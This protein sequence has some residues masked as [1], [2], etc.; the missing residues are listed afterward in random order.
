MKT[1]VLY[2]IYYALFGFFALMP[3]WLLFIISD[4]F[5]V[6][7]YKCL[8]YRV[9]MVRK[10]LRNSFPEKTDE[11]LR[12]IEKKVYHHFCDLIVETV[13][14]LN[15][16][17]AQAEERIIVVNPEIVVDVEKQNRPVILYLGHY[18]NWEYVTKIVRHFLP[19]KPGGHVYKPQH[20]AAMDKFLYKL[21]SRFGSIG[22]EQS[23]TF[24]RLLAWRRDHGTFVMGFIA[25][26]RPSSNFLHNWTTFLNQDTA[27]VAGGE[28]IGKRVD[29]AYM[30]VEVE[31]TSRGHYRLTFKP[32]E[33][34][35]DLAGEKYP[36]TLQY[37]R[38]FEQ[39]ICR[40]PQYWLW[41]HNRWRFTREHQNN[42]GK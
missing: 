6:L 9:K 25:D 38:M 40:E 8:H 32:I 42:L 19:D 5:Y 41:S 27:Y 15:I 36:Y 11:E 2:A 24:R 4:C 22:V 26:H 23:Q 35:A 29:A 12:V 39:T 7:I 20:D 21:R 10:N 30:Y 17:D 31:K 28:E 34:D 37:L 16:S 1:K 3:F 13:K 14:L 33:P 18:A